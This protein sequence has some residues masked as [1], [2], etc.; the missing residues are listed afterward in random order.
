MIVILLTSRASTGYFSNSSDSSVTNRRFSLSPGPRPGKKVSAR[1]P[2]LLN[3]VFWPPPWPIHTGYGWSCDRPHSS[4]HNSFP[5]FSESQSFTF[6]SR[7]YDREG[8]SSSSVFHRLHFLWLI[9][10][11]PRDVLPEKRTQP[12]AF[13]C[14]YFNCNYFS[15]DPKLALQN[16]RLGLELKTGD[17]TQL[18]KTLKPSSSSLRTLQWRLEFFYFGS[19]NSI[20]E[21]DVFERV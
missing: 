2:S 15:A 1:R 8:E 10:S 7:A 20:S 9:A 16:Y 19:P 12:L 17:S 3:A 11:S 21:T 18:M 14:A 4:F 13:T 6:R 5:I